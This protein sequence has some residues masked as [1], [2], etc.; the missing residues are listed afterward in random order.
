MEWIINLNF[1][2]NEQALS[3]SKQL[4]LIYISLHK[5]NI[6]LLICTQ[7]VLNLYL[8]HKRERANSHLSVRQSMFNYAKSKIF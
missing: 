5:S 6:T 4:E 2:Y 8:Q 3:V 7:V 1:K